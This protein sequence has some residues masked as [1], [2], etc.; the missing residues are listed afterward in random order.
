MTVPVAFT[1]LRVPFSAFR[2]TS[3]F[4]FDSD[5]PDLPAVLDPAR[6]VSLALRFEPARRSLPAVMMPGESGSSSERAPGSA[7]RLEINRIKV[8]LWVPRWQGTRRPCLG[9]QMK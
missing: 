1:N 4:A 3:Y 6:V 9:H 8:E 5:A 2:A 7:F